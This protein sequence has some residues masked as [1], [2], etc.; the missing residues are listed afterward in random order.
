MEELRLYCLVRGDL[1]IP[2]GKLCAQTAHG[3]LGSYVNCTNED[4]KKEYLGLN[5]NGLIDSGQA[6]I[7]LK[8]KNLNALL[9]AEQECKDLG[10]S[11]ALIKDAG[12]TVFNE[13][14][15]TVLGIGPVTKENLPKFVQKMQLFD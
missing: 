11:T 15:I 4:L 13:P 6:K 9:R 14:T 10:I 1:E 2:I 12:R 3:F 8:A 7:T 5:E